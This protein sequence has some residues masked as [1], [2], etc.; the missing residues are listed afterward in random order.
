MAAGGTV[1]MDALGE[2]AGDGGAGHDFRCY[3]G[4]CGFSGHHCPVSGARAGSGCAVSGC[5]RTGGGGGG[6]GARGVVARASG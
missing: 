1:A 4:G 6:W 5:G 3:G 2:V